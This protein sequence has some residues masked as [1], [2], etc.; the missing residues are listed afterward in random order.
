LVL[1]I[2]F[3]SS[4]LDHQKYKN[5]RA[6]IWDLMRQWFEDP[7]GVQVPDQDEFQSDVCAPVRGKGATRF[8]S[9]GRL[10]LEDKD[11]IKE[12]LTYSPDLGDAAALT[13]AVD[14]SMLDETDWNVPVSPITGAGAWMRA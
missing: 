12:R 10:I 9:A 6:E 3:S 4:A 11:H 8:D 13:F 14:M 1:G 2:N 7:A 5:R